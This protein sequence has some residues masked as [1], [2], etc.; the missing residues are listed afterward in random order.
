VLS[1]P[2]LKHMKKLFILIG[3]F[4]AAPALADMPMQMTPAETK[5]MQQMDVS[6]KLMDH[7]MAAP[8]TG[9]VDR[10]FAIMMIPHHQGAIEM[11][12]GEL[13]Y[14]K[15]PVMRRLAQEIIVDQESEIQLMNRW[16]KKDAEAPKNP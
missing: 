15:D 5:F 10:D 7:D 6:M 14:G 3:I 1:F 9:S 8:M 11:A 2:T 16:L 12:K 4:L 13:S